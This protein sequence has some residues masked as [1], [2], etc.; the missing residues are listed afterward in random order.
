MIAIARKHIFFQFSKKTF[1]V[2]SPG[3]SLVA[4][5]ELIGFCAFIIIIYLLF[6][7]RD[8]FSRRFPG[9]DFWRSVCRIERNF[10]T[11]SHGFFSDSTRQNERVYRNRNNSDINY[12]FRCV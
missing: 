6:I 5:P 12:N 7:L 1:F 11:L 3:G 8:A 2:K 10:G 9:Y 4:Y